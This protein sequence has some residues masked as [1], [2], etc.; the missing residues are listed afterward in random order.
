MVFIKQ[1]AAGL[2]AL[3]LSVGALASSVEVGGIKLEDTADVQGTKLPLNGAGVRTRA[4]FKVY[5]AALYTGKKVAN[6]EELAA[7]PGPKRMSMTM[8]RDI[9][10]NELGKA[11]TKG[12]EENSPK[13]EMSKLIP[14]LIRMG[15]IFSDQ[16]KMVPG[17]VIL[18]DWVPGTGMIVTAKGKVQGEPFKEVEFFNAMM[19]IWLGASPADAR[20]KD[21]LLGIK[22]A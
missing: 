22:P 16:K 11:F 17:D 14:G 6:A 5:V 8:L 13:G 1:C 21:A 3:I 4:I 20:L 12:F 18:L 7:A 19:R 15:Q 10:A 2:A 9:D